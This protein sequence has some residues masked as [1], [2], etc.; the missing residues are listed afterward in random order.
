MPLILGG[1][2][3][4]LVVIVVVLVIVFTSG[5][6]PVTPVAG[7][8]GGNL[9]QPANQ[10]PDKPTAAEQ[11][12]ALEGELFM[13]AGRKDKSGLQSV[14]TRARSKGLSGVARKAAESALAIDPDLEWANLEVGNRDLKEIFD[15]I[16]EDDILDTYANAEYE[17][18]VEEREYAESHWGT[19]EKVDELSKLLDAVLTHFN[20]LKNDRTYLDEYV[21]RLNVMRDPV[22]SKYKFRVESK[23]PYIMFVE[24][25]GDK[26]G[27]QSDAQKKR[28]AEAEKI[29]A[30]N[31]TL[32]HTLYSQYMADFKVPFN[33]PEISDLEQPSMRVLKVWTFSSHASFLQYQKDIGMQ[34]P[35]GVGAY[36]RPNN[37][38]VTLFEQAGSASSGQ[39]NRSDF[40]TNKVVHEAFHQIMHT[41]SKVVLERE[42][43]E[44]VLWGD[45]RTQSRLH[46]FQ[47][48]MADFYGSA[49]SRTGGKWT[50]KVPYR[51]RLGEWFQTRKNK[52]SDWSFEELR[53]IRSGPELQQR[54]RRK[55]LNQRGRLVSLFYAESWTWCYF[56]YNFEDGKYREKLIEYIGKE[57]KGLSGPEEFAKTWGAGENYDWGP[58][59]KEWRGYVEKLWADQGFK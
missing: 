3:L 46:W 36:Y 8:G 56:L 21:I 24:F 16:P 42:T 58:V 1:A 39:A 28:A 44:E 45:S 54:A 35:A 30:R 57:L 17:T 26:D 23:S 50:L 48:G 43:G 27:V 4:G 52:L 55:G 14:Y 53:N 31:L 37:Q 6:D 19:P 34:L 11:T 38:W 32:L 2:G 12:R 15:K 5:K 49:T 10:A 47:E 20:K 9:G 41:F 7:G 33:L 22:Y 59:E 51:M 40:N 25:V 13:F 18:L 29:V